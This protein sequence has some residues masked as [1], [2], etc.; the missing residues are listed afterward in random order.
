[1]TPSARRVRNYRSVARSQSVALHPEAGLNDAMRTLF[2][3]M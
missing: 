1:M 3:G 2:E